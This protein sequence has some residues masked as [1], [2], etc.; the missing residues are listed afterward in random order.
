ML[1]TLHHYSDKP[2]VLDRAC[3]Y[4][5]SGAYKPPGLWVSVPGEDDWPAWCRAEDFCVEKLAVAHRVTLAAEANV[6]LLTTAKELDAFATKFGHVP[7]HMRQLS[8]KYAEID[9][10]AVARS[11]QGLVIAP[12]QHSR[13]FTYHWYYGWDCA[14]GVLWDLRAV[15]SVE[16]VAEVSA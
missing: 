7:E 4:E 9:W 5:S 1:P 13:R 16:P 11:W 12:Y 2:V 15:A 10:A 8:F 6:L 14:S 3:R